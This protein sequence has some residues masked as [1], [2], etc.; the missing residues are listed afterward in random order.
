MA[1]LSSAELK[2][3]I[4]GGNFDSVDQDN[5][6]YVI[7]KTKTSTEQTIV[8]EI[9]ELVKDYLNIEFDGNYN[10]IVQSKWVQWTIT[11][12]YN[13]DPVSRDTYSQRALAFRGFGNIEEG[14][15]P[16]LSKDKLFSNTVINTVCGEN[17]TAPFY[18][19]D[20][21]TSEIVYKQDLTT[22]LTLVGG[23]TEAFS[24]DKDI[25]INPVL[26][27]VTIDKISSST[28]NPDES[29]ST[30]QFPNNTTELNY[31]LR[32]GTSKTIEVKCIDECKN[33][34]H[35]ISFINK[36]GVMQ[37]IWFFAR[38]RESIT[39]ERQQYKK[40]TLNITGETASYDISDHQ[41]VYLEN[42]GREVLTM[43]TGYIH[44]SYNEVIKEL[45]VSEYVYIHD[46]NRSS[47]SDPSFGLAVPIEIVTNSLQFKQRRYDK[48]I[49]YQLQFE[50]DSELIQSVR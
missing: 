48:L 12:T 8:F 11:R 18:Q 2:L 44:E 26:D 23:T 6:N 24:V 25:S 14:I 17:I 45:M 37:D 42:Q 19:G 38:K 35:K 10:N 30:V 21:G 29:T 50:V 22:L 46:P 4:Y 27:L 47:P 32:D 49:D 9:S 34:P 40:N 7:T 5:P 33:K 13:T 43:N 39:S 15:N 16:E 3:Y 28:T 31:T 36:F 1:D 20:E 41:R